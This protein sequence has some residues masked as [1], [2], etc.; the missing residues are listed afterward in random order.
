MKK[1]E[2]F[3]LD[4][5]NEEV[6]D[7]TSAYA[8]LNKKYAFTGQSCGYCGLTMGACH[9]KTVKGCNKTVNTCRTL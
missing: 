3:E 5:T 7:E 6:N 9:K 4:L 8:V 2:E 1:Y